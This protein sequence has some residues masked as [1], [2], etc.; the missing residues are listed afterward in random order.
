MKREANAQQ[1]PFRPFA[2]SATGFSIEMMMS[3]PVTFFLIIMTQSF[4]SFPLMIM[5]MTVLSQ[6]MKIPQNSRIYSYEKMR[7]FGSFLKHCG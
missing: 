4:A 1:R 3:F 6:C 2:R 5:Y 7:H